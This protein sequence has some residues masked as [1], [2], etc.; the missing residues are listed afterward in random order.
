MAVSLLLETPCLVVCN[1]SVRVVEMLTSSPEWDERAGRPLDK[2]E[3]R[4]K[5][6]AILPVFLAPL[7]CRQSADASI[8]GTCNAGRRREESRRCGRRGRHQNRIRYP[9][10]SRV[11]CSPLQFFVQNTRVKGPALFL[12]KSQRTRMERRPFVVDCVKISSCYLR[13]G[14]GRF[15]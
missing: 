8:C 2:N 13:F 10:E 7:F 15:K 6:K 9:P 11:E 5:H 1:R 12:H 3:V 4:V 14:F